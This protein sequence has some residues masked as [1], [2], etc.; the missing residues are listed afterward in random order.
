[1]TPEQQRAIALAKARKRKAEQ[2]RQQAPQQAMQQNIQQAPQQEVPAGAPQK[3]S[4]LQRAQNFGREALE[5]AQTPEGLRNIG[6]TVGGLAGATL[7]APV[8]VP[9]AIA[10]GMLGGSLGGGVPSALKQLTGR[11]AEMPQQQA[12]ETAKEEIISGGLIKAGGVAARPI[13]TLV[14]KAAGLSEEV[15]TDLLKKADSM[16][17]DIGAM[18][19]TDNKYLD[20]FIRVMGMIPLVGSPIKKAQIK[21]GEQIIKAKDN[22]INE[23]APNA[24]LFET[25]IDLSNAAK[26][27]FKKFT[28]VANT[29][30]K[31][32]ENRAQ[33][34]TVKEIFDAKPIREQLQAIKAQS[35]QEQIPGVKGELYTEAKKYIN[36]LTENMP[37]KLT[38][39]QLRG[40]Q[41]KVNELAQEGATQGK[42]VGE[43][44]DVKKATEKALNNPDIS[45]LPENEAEE[46]IASL[47]NA[48]AFYANNIGRFKSS[49][50]NRFG[51]VDKNA[52]DYKFSKAG[53]RPEDQTFQAVFN[54]KSPQAMSEL[55]D[56]VGKNKFRD[57]FGS[58]VSNAMEESI[59]GS[60]VTGRDFLDIKKF[61]KKVG[62][63][64]KEGRAVLLEGLK[65]S[66]VDIK[67]LD[68]FAEIVTRVGDVP[69]PSTG[70]FLQRRLTLGGL[71]S[72]GL[73]AA[74][75]AGFYGMGL[76]PVAT[77]GAIGRRGSKVMSDPKILK[78]MT[79]ALNPKQS[80]VVRKRAYVAAI[81]SLYGEDAAREE[82]K[83]IENLNAEDLFGRLK[84][85][86]DGAN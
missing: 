53:T 52:F 40:I 77:L 38:V 9:A 39:Q 4:A 6:A 7:A 68:N 58:Y 56:I 21:Q 26:G 63:N 55:R 32:F 59:R 12:R 74:G 16:G 25:G 85:Q 24:T 35:S 48:N 64:S 10:T 46:L 81:N 15:A 3:A 83:T 80:D 73:G 47:K 11:E 22:L 70:S 78:N 51:R 2:T 31:D 33:N 27:R 71:S 50:A 44:F 41:R 5:Y 82:K 72:F 61:V 65:D 69:I 30:Y 19:V 34:A 45:K 66:K 76:L 42:Q 28:R 36:D 1:M 62:L 17:I 60:A 79:K 84:E 23:L 13:K 57:A 86:N 20:G 29:L 67:D 8:G 37:E 75:T 43:L 14:Q 54:A 49:T 18:N